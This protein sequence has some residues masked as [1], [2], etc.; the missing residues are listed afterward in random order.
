MIPIPRYAME[1]QSSSSSV[2]GKP[3]TN[4]RSSRF[5][6]LCTG[7]STPYTHYRLFRGRPV[8]THSIFAAK[9]Y[10]ALFPQMDVWP[11]CLCAGLVRGSR[12]VR[13]AKNFTR[14]ENTFRQVAGNLRFPLTV[15]YHGRPCNTLSAFILKQDSVEARHRTT[16]EVFYDTGVPVT[17]AVL[18]DH[19]YRKRDFSGATRIFP[20]LSLIRPRFRLCR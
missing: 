6:G 14:R 4:M 8:H 20:G 16:P 12:T 2:I 1:R 15:T 11:R 3:S 17:S 10:S 7:A 18:G 13:Y 19:T 5:W 9:A